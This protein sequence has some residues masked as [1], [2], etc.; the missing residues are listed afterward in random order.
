MYPLGPTQVALG[1]VVGLDYHDAD[2]RRARAAAADE[3]ASAVPRRSSRAAQLLEWGAKTIPEGGY[4][5]LPDGATATALLIVGDTVGLRGCPVAQ[6]HPLRHAVG[7]VRGAG[8]LRG[9][10]GGRRLGG[11]ARRLR[12]DGGRQLYRDRSAPHA[13]TC[14]SH[15]RTGSS[16]AGLKAGLMTVTGGRF[17]GRKDR[18]AE[19]CR[20]PR[21][22]SP[23]RAVHARTDAHLQ[24]ARRG[25]QVRQ[26]HARY[27]PVPPASSAPTSRPRW[28]IST[29][30][31]ARPASTS[32]WVTS[33]GSTTELR[34]LQG[35]RRAGP[36]V[37]AAGRRERAQVSL[38]VVRGVPAG[39]SADR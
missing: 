9:A 10:Q 7:D 34:R 21:D 19:R 8:R 26:R 11:G 30:T 29:P 17:P 2:A 4:Y 12:Q 6:G 1:L 15:S 16:S 23:A 14:A 33:S 27:H 20:V 22:V 31:C 36:A 24:Q 35:D 39:V 38:H 5:A 3:A 25:L 13:A 32:A 28:R 18:H 37:D